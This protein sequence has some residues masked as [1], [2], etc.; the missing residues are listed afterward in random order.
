M[1]QSCIKLLF[2][3]SITCESERSLARCI[4]SGTICIPL[5]EKRRKLTRQPTISSLLAAKAIAENEILTLSADALREGTVLNQ[6]AREHLDAFHRVAD[7]PTK[8]RRLTWGSIGSAADGFAVAMQA[9]KMPIQRRGTEFVQLFACEADAHKRAWVNSVVNGELRTQS[10]QSGQD[11]VC[12]FC[13]HDDLDKSRSQCHAHDTQCPVPSVDVLFACASEK[14]TDRKDAGAGRSVLRRLFAY[15]D[16][17]SVQIVIFVNTQNASEACGRVKDDT[18][19]VNMFCAEMSSRGFEGQRLILDDSCFGLPHLRKKL[20]GVFVKT[21]NGLGPGI[22]G[23]TADFRR[24]SVA[25]LFTSLKLLVKMCQRF[26]PDVEDVL[27]RPDDQAIE[28][29][30]LRCVRDGAAVDDGGW[31]SA[32]HKLYMKLRLPINVGSPFSSTYN[33]PWFH[34]LS[35]AQKSMLIY[36]QRHIVASKTEV[37][38]AFRQ[39]DDTSVARD[40]VSKFMI[41]LAPTSGTLSSSSQYEFGSEKREVAPCLS[42]KQRWW[43]HSRSGPERLMLPRESL[44]LQ[45]YP[46]GSDM[47]AQRLGH[48]KGPHERFLSDLTGTSLPLTVVVAVFLAAWRAVIW[49]DAED[50]T[51]AIEKAFHIE[52]ATAEEESLVDDLLATALGQQTE[53]A[54][55]TALDQ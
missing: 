39:A 33:S 54:A 52:P 44:V 10:N 3:L 30:L 55:E 4:M 37:C 24:R 16:T 2:V 43:L 13:S 22:L 23:P 42:S 5:R 20:Y 34:V 8:H 31:L 50:D 25:D 11:K 28:M 36:H 19:P 1:K 15:L 7:W 18:P 17:H 49:R 40:F 6:L 9:C 46:V 21:T 14:D 45:A 53:P 47:F 51:K 48:V 29:E 12:I 32:V 41:D 35:P 27:L 38:A 26:P